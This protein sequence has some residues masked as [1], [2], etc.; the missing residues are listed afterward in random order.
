MYEN[1]Q[2]ET[3]K[4]LPGLDFQEKHTTFL[5]NVVAFNVFFY[6]C[7]WSVKLSLLLFFR[8]LRSKQRSHQVWW[9]CV[10]GVC[11]VTWAACVADIQ[12][13]C[14]VTSFEHVM[15]KLGPSKH[16]IAD[17]MVKHIV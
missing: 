16:D 12:W 17:A 15:C 11:V 4:R 7:L 3:Q 1:N 8:R 14:T 13:Q 10:L 6:S 9:W 2:V 5:H